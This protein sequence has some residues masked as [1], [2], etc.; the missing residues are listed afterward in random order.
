[1]AGSLRWFRYTLDDGENVGVFLDES[2][3]EVLNGGVANTP[4]IGQRP[5]R[6]RPNGTRL[7]SI[8]YKTADGLRTIKCVALTQQIY[9]GV[10]AALATIPNP[11]PASGTTGGGQLAF[12]SKQPEL[13][14]PPR[15]G[16][17]TGLNDGDNP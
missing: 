8:T 2:N 3:T 13:V 5:T 16:I 12:W 7:R 14:K 6:Q 1:M 9:A 17:D 11:L 4:P 15:F 10:P